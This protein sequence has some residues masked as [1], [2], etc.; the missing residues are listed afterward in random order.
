MARRMNRWAE[1]FKIGYLVFIL[2]FA[3]VP[4]LVTIVVSFKTNEQFVQNPWFF[5]PVSEWQWGNWATAWEQVSGYIWNSVF[6]SVSG[7][8]I[9]IVMV[10]MCSYALA[11]YRFP[12]RELVYYGIMATM[13]LPGTAATLVTVFNLLKNL[14]LV[15]SLVALVVMAA[16]GGQVVGVFVIRQFIEDIPKELFDS[17]AIDGAGHLQQIWHIIVPLSGSVIAIVCILDFLGSWN[18]VILPLVLLRDDE[19]LT[20]PVGLFRLD[21]EYVKQYGPLMAGYAISSLPLLLIF[22][23]SMKLFVKGMTA[24]AVK[25]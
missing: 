15:N 14:G 19:L 5:D 2:F 23:F 17:A 12:G 11:R 10:L 21:G 22:L 3:F 18:N 9:T 13:F 20:I 8:L 7:T 6:V 16:V 1:A 24:G 25:G 4:F